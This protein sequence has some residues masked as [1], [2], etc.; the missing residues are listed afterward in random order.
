MSNAIF[1][2]HK[3]GEMIVN[4]P[5]DGRKHSVK[6]DPHSSKSYDEAERKVRQIKDSIVENITKKL[7]RAP[8]PRE[9]QQGYADGVDVRTAREKMEDSDWRPKKKETKS[10]LEKLLDQTNERIEA[11]K[12]YKGMSPDEARRADLEAM[13]HRDHAEAA[14][15]EA[16]KRHLE[17]IA[18]KL[19]L[20]ERL[21]N[22]ERWSPTASEAFRATLR[23]CKQ[24]LM[25]VDGCPQE[26]AELLN[27][28]RDIVRHRKFTK[29]AALQKQQ[30]L[31]LSE[32][33]ETQKE[34]DEL[35]P[36]MVEEQVV[37]DADI[38]SETIERGISDADELRRYK[39]ARRWNY[40]GD[41][42]QE[43]AQTGKL[44]EVTE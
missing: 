36:D 33:Q 17:R 42:A 25:T 22:A 23:K 12:P 41:V 16:E 6:F 9:L 20:I 24:Q 37:T 18:P 39:D 4:S 10:P 7:G 8:S 30:M 29:Q 19:Q 27:D 38:E 34:L 35:E 13:I 15:L 32:M 31:L 40:G 14:A 44:P 43:Y 28:I 1:V 2:Q 3:R 26:T 11:A 5:Y 21:T